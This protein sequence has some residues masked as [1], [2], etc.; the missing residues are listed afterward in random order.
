MILIYT[1]SDQDGIVDI[2]DACPFEPETYN[3]YQDHDGCPDTLVL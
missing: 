3:F 1:D 2:S